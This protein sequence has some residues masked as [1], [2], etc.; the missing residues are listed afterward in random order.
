MNKKDYINAVDNIT[1]PQGLLDRIE[2]IKPPAKKK[3]PV[4]K[5]ITAVAA[6]FVVVTIAF[7]GI[8]GGMLKAESGNAIGNSVDD[9]VLFDSEYKGNSSNISEESSSD[10]STTISTNR[11]IVKSASL[12]I[13]TKNYDA[14]ITELKQKIE[15]Y[16]GYIEQSQEYNYDNTT[17]RD[18][19]MEVKIPAENFE[20]FVD[21]LA[22]IGTITSKTIT[23][24]DITD[25][26]IDV[27]SRIKALETEKETLL[28]ILEKAQSLADVIE[29]QDRISVVRTELE[30]VKAQKQSYD[31][32]VAYSEVHLNINEVERVVEV[33]NTFFGE[34]KEKL[35]NNLYDLGDFFRELAI[36]LIASSPY[37]AIIGV[38]AVVVIVIVK[39]ARKR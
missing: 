10:A 28:G 16:E 30:S 5:I 37:I 24:D 36:N 19:N 18:A 23:S 9:E 15:Q 38:V 27:E 11:K 8:F 22:E 6:C 26:Y 3:T 13:D 20:E 2:A 7:S 34:I 29:L 1:A 12:D 14:F 32:M 25:S 4:W 31:A 33:D 17:D 39:K 35:M 21:G